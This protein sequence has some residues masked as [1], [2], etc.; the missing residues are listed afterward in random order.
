MTPADWDREPTSD[1]ERARWR[2]AAEPYWVVTDDS[3]SLTVAN[4]AT[5]ELAAEAVHSHNVL[6]AAREQRAL[7]VG[8]HDGCVAREAGLLWADDEEPWGVEF[9]E[10]KGGNYWRN[11]WLVARER[12]E[13]RAIATFEFGEHAEAFVR[14]FG[15]RT[16]EHGQATRGAK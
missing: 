2:V 11:E 12:G 5:P 1:A 8:L 14:A 7:G 16:D 6:H 4:F 13:G 15:P 3:P 9:S 10:N